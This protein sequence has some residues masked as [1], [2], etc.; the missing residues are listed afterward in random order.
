[1]VESLRSSDCRAQATVIDSQTTI[2]SFGRKSS[3]HSQTKSS[4][5]H[6]QRIIHCFSYL[7]LFKVIWSAHTHAHTYTHT[8]NR[9]ES[10]Q[11]QAEFFWEGSYWLRWLS[12]LNSEANQCLLCGN[13]F[14]ICR[15][16]RDECHTQ[17]SYPSP[18]HFLQSRYFQWNIILMVSQNS[19]K[20]W[21]QL[22]SSEKINAGEKVEKTRGYSYLMLR[23]QIKT[24]R[25]GPKCKKK[26]GCHTKHTTS[27][28][29]QC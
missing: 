1:M 15:V 8:H 2:P 29:Y 9:L 17:V 28:S 5:V 23:S 26:V 14:N 7:G 19:V 11:Q 16:R 22:R 27:A 25:Q 24:D 10:Y 6:C 3:A 4:L 18:S 13:P 12:T 21:M 20:K